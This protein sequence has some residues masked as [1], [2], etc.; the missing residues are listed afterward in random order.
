MGKRSK[1]RNKLWK[2]PAAPDNQ[3]PDST[4]ALSNAYKKFVARFLRQNNKKAAIPERETAS[5]DALPSLRLLLD[6]TAEIET[7]IQS[8]IQSHDVVS[9]PTNRKNPELDVAGYTMMTEIDIG[10]LQ[11]CKEET[12]A[13]VPEPGAPAIVKNAI[14]MSPQIPHNS[15]GFDEE[16]QDNVHITPSRKPISTLTAQ[17][18]PCADPCRADWTPIHCIPDTKF[19]KVLSK[20]V[21]GSLATSDT[22]YSFD[23]E[24]QGGYNYVRIYTLLTGT[25]AGKYAIKVPSVGT[26]SR[27]K[28]QDAYMLRSEFGTMRLIRERTNCPV[29]HVIAYS[30]SLDNELGA[31]YI[32]MK[33]CAGQPAIDLWYGNDTEGCSETGDNNNNDDSSG[34][35]ESKRVRFL[36]SLASA[37]AELRNL[38]FDKI[39]VLDFDNADADGTPA[40][41]RGWLWSVPPYFTAE[42]MS[43]DKPF[44]EL[45]VHASSRSLFIDGLLGVRPYNAEKGSREMVFH[46]LME[47]VLRSDPFVRSVK[48]GDNKETFVL[49]HDDLDLQNVFCDP[50]TGEVTCILD[51]ERASTAPR[52]LGYS[53][54]PLFLVS[55]WF[56]EYPADADGDCPFALEKYRKIYASAMVKATSQDGDGKYTHKSAMYQAAYAALF[57]GAYGGDV[58]D[59]ITKVLCQIPALNPTD[60]D[61]YLSWLGE[62][63]LTD[64]DAVEEAIVDAVKPVV[65]KAE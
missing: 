8:T 17:T 10:F 15:P 1:L 38:E 47:T 30:D 2:G 20:H 43:T 60:L 24:L 34:V 19:F 11:E 42:D 5:T 22:D 25:F 51:W 37:M 36:R 56:P 18:P 7:A 32:L 65:A 29:P 41:G 6:T 45:P 57:G 28:K 64:G 26:S 63:W 59:F 49:R 31:P 48:P 33:A 12:K 61:V 23:C 50:E 9:V 53:S 21:G 62:H 27:W 58:S 4:S 16:P 3:T 35:L 13:G 44:Y 39:G 55:D 54:L 40:V 52:C 46:H 14:R